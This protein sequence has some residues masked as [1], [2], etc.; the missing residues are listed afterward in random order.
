MQR[1]R[2]ILICSIL[3]LA[4]STLVM[5]ADLPSGI[6]MNH[7]RSEIVSGSIDTGMTPF[8]LPPIASGKY[9]EVDFS[10]KNTG[11][12]PF[13]VS[14]LDFYL[15]SGHKTFSPSN[16]SIYLKNSLYMTNVNPGMEKKGSIL[17]ELPATIKDFS[18]EYS[19]D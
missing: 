19:K 11:D 2:F 3:F 12:S 17:F 13:T 7:L 6:Q 14:Y 4:V 16:Q 5:A 15:K 1:L 9:I 8:S 18:L 10:L